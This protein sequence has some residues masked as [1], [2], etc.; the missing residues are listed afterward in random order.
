MK[1]VILFLL[2]F[3]L[4]GCGFQKMCDEG[5]TLKGNSCVQKHISDAQVEYTCLNDYYLKDGRCY[6]SNFP[7]GYT[8]KPT[9]KYY[10]T[11][12]YLKNDKCIV[13]TTYDAYIDFFRIDE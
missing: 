9:K 8:R 13:E 2:L 5:D 11:S 10:C 4:T 6:H 1:K 3:L 12:G 7:N